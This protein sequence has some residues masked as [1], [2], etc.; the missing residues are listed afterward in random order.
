MVGEVPDFTQMNKGRLNEKLFRITGVSFSKQE[1]IDLSNFYIVLDFELV[2][3]E[4]PVNFDNISHG[5]VS[6]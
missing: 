3:A 6:P 1:K 2:E 4:I 5:D